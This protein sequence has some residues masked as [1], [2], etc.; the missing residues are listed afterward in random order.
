M[1]FRQNPFKREDLRRFFSVSGDL[2]L[3]SICILLVT[4]TVTSM[5]ARMGE[6]VL[7]INTVTMQFFLFFSYF[8]DGFAYAG[9]ALCGKWSG[10]GAKA[11]LR[12]T[13]RNLFKWAFLTAVI[14]TA[15]YVIGYSDIV[16]LITDVSDVKTGV[17]S[18]HSVVIAIPLV[19]AWAFILDG[20]FIGL[21][22]TR[23]MFITIFIGTVA[24][25]IIA[26]SGFYF[27]SEYSNYYLWMAFLVYLF[28]RGIGLLVQLPAF[29]R[30][31]N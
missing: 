24:F 18:M 1:D 19:S 6:R 3:R 9:E 2:V 12:L 26:L 22:A 7:A 10:S 17:F 11:K 20:I 27:N 15:F 21:A 4:L 29:L 13:V 16:S 8:M 31:S 23:R 28:I 5:G 14:F 25:M 30:K